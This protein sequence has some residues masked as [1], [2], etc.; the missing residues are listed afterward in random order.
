MAS[1]NY[2]D[3][4]FQDGQKCGMGTFQWKD[5]RKYTGMWKDNKRHGYGISVDRDGVSSEGVWGKGEF[6]RG[7]DN[8]GN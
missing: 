5:G 7:F 1:G 8:S 6:L 4:E 2:Y 3:G